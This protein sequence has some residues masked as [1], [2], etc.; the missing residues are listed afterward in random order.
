MPQAIL[1]LFTKE[2][3]I[4]NMHIGVIQRDGTVYYFQGVLPLS[5]QSKR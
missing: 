1:P 4:V 2:T 3:T 5:A